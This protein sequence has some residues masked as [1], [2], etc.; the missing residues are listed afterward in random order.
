MQQGESPRCNM[1]QKKPTLWENF[2]DSIYM[3]F[4]NR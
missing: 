3:K 1:E 2:Y 4:K